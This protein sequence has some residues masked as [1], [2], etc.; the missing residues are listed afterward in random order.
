MILWLNGT[1]RDESE[2]VI[3]A[4]DHGFLYGMGLFETFRTYGGKPF[5]LSEH[6][7]RLREG[8]IAL[9]IAYDPDVAEIE[10][11]VRELIRANGLDEAYVRW[12][13]SAGPAPLGLPGAEGYGR[14]NVLL[15][16]KPLPGTAPEPKEL[17]LLRLPRSGPEGAV[18]Q[19]SFHYMNN[20]LGKW[21]LAERTKSPR[22]EGLFLDAGGRLC[23]GIVSNL[24]WVSGGRLFTPSPD[25]GCLPGI[26]RSAVLALA[27]RAG[28]PCSEG[29]FPVSALAGAD[30]AFVTN[31]VQ[32]VVPVQALFGRNGELARRW[33]AAPG[34]ITERLRDLY[35][36]WTAAEG[37]Q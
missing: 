32:E 37:A 22:A 20:I 24:F 4:G 31:S 9:R 33:D 6:A 5:L 14:P 1:L 7:G 34:E 10:R 36:K 13:V 30:E 12:S 35:R 3:P 16:A 18:R 23:E 2:A 25:T 17:H 21:E 26:T 27:D 28:I 15:M 29:G 8:C 11:A 19:K